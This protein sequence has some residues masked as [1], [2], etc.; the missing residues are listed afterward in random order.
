MNIDPKQQQKK[1]RLKHMKK[2]APL[3]SKPIYASDR[4]LSFLLVIAFIYSSFF[5]IHQAFAEPTLGLS[6]SWKLADAFCTNPNYKRSPDEQ[7]F[8]DAIKHVGA[9]WTDDVVEI[10][11]SAPGTTTGSNFS[12]LW[13]TVFTMDG[14]SCSQSQKFTTKLEEGGKIRLE[15]TDGSAQTTNPGS[16]PDASIKCDPAH[17]ATEEYDKIEVVTDHFD[18]IS[19]TGDDCGEFHFH[20]QKN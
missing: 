13:T 6:G 16:N 11:S 12:G 2:V 19:N 15:F 14:M 7:A 1:S 8:V 5:C 10:N 20:F 9:T 3:M 4:L 18:L 17:G